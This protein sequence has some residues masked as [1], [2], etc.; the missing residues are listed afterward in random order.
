M[1]AHFQGSTFPCFISSG[2]HRTQFCQEVWA[3]RPTSNRVLVLT[4][5]HQLEGVSSLPPPSPNKYIRHVLKRPG[6]SWIIGALKIRMCSLF[7]F[8]IKHSMSLQRKNCLF[9]FHLFCYK[10]LHDKYCTCIHVAKNYVINVFYLFFLMFAVKQQTL[11]K[12]VEWSQIFVI[13]IFCKAKVFPMSMSIV[14]CMTDTRIS[15][16]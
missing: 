7:P 10:L 9:Y 14:N 8:K 16:K 11:F 4:H 13:S 2:R 15:I 3:V 1:A 12:M 5:P 6:P